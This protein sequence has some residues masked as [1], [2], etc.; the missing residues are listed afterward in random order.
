[1][2][3]STIISDGFFEDPEDIRKFAFQQ[4]Y[5][6]CIEG[7]WPGVRTE[8][9]NVIA[10]VFG[11]YL[12]EKL[13]PLCFRGGKSVSLSSYF[14]KIPIFCDDPADVRNRGF[15]HTDNH[16]D[17]KNSIYEPNIAGIV[18]LNPITH[19]RCGTSIYTLVPGLEKTKLNLAV[20]EKQALFKH[21]K[22]IDNFDKSVAEHYAQFH[23]SVRVDN[24]YNRLISFD[25]KQWHGCRNFHTGTDEHRLTLVWFANVEF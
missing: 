12:V 6:P 14:Q 11:K 20:P 21:G 5:A 3:F 17:N 10:P 18:Y 22:Y 15:V 25:A 7:R 23:E 1:M 2:T 9:L 16:Y 8:S 19:T 4:S 13:V 24:V